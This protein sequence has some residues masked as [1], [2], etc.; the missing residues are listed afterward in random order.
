[1]PSAS[2]NCSDDSD[3]EIERVVFDADWTII[4]PDRDMDADEDFDFPFGRSYVV[5]TAFDA[6]H[7]AI[8]DTIQVD[9]F[10]ET[11]PVTIC[12]D[13]L[14]VG[15]SGTKGSEEDGLVKVPASSFD[16]G[17][18]DDCGLKSTCVVRMDDLETF[19][20][21]DTD[22]DGWVAIA[23]LSNTFSCE[24]ADYYAQYARIIPG[25]NPAVNG[26][27][28]DDLC[29]SE[30]WFCCSDD[31]NDVMVVFRAEDHAGNINECMVSVDVQDKTRPSITC[32]VDVIVDCELPLPSVPETE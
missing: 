2:D 5:Y 8:K 31:G 28:R 12:K 4:G 32:P 22:D 20:G 27:H 16:N 13:Q 1:M 26:I 15:I 25:S 30:I 9:I 19:D 17:T 24:R 10:D 3:I 23:E 11:A 21:L 7:N 6:C 29:Q 14:V 18:Y